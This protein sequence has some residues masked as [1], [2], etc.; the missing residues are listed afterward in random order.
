MVVLTM[1]QISFWDVP[2]FIRV[3]PVM[4]SGP[5]TIVLLAGLHRCH[6][7][8]SAATGGNADHDIFGSDVM[9]VP[10]GHPSF[11]DIILG[12]FQVQHEILVA[13][14][15]HGLPDF[16]I[17]AI[18]IGHLQHVQ[19]TEFAAGAGAEP[20]EAPACAELRLD[21]IYKFFYVRE[22]SLDSE[23]HLF[24]FVVDVAKKFRNRFLFEMVVK[25]RL[26]S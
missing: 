19:D 2:D 3:L 21:G 9:L 4:N 16:R 24:V 25:R 17:Y 14:C 7:V 5:Q 23:G 6:H 10:E 15:K 12:L 22:H 1:S 26:L 11:V 13:A 18:G 8:G 20:E